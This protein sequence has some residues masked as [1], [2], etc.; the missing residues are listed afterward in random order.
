MLIDEIRKASMQAMKDHDQE[1]RA[2]Y[3]MV[4][5]RYQALLTSGKGKEVTDKDV[6][7]ILIKFSKELEEERQGYLNAGRNETAEGIAK[8]TEAV[9][10]FLPKLLSEEEIRSIIEK[11]EDKSIPS[12]MRFFKANYDGKADMG[13]VS[14]VAR[15]LQ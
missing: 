5:S 2:A 9:A 3:S 14:K 7:A 4:I 12:V 13:L 15:S 11:L 6:T 1:A 10:K 8:Q